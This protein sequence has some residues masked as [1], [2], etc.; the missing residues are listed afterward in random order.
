M[1][2]N[3]VWIYV[4]MTDQ[5]Y[6]RVFENMLMGEKELVPHHESHNW[7]F[8]NIVG[9]ITKEMLESERY[10][11]VNSQDLMSNALI[12]YHTESLMEMQFLSLITFAFIYRIDESSVNYTVYSRSDQVLYVLIGEHIFSYLAG[13]FRVWEIS[14]HGKVDLNG[15]ARA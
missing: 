14:Q 11:E 15:V 12:T 9:C 5:G 7:V 6:S 13:I 3:S 1:L 10:K 2:V 4:K 8:E